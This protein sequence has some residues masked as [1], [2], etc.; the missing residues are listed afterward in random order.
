M[1]RGRC[2]LFVSAL[3]GCLSP[4]AAEP[5]RKGE[6]PRPRTALVLAGGGAL[7]FAHVGV[8][9]VLEE[10]RVPVD[11]VTG[12][13]M[14]AIVG[15]AYASGRS[16]K[17][18]EKV[19]SETDWDKLFDEQPQ[20]RTLPYRFK[21]GRKREIYGDTK[22]GFKDGAL[23]LP[24]GVVSGQNVL[25]VLQSLYGDTPNPVRFDDLPLPFRAVTADIETG[26]AFVPDN[27]DLSTIVRASM[28]VPG[29]F[30][31]VEVDGKMLVDGGITDNLPIDVARSMGAERFIV[32]ELNADLKDRKQL[33]S[34][35]LAIT[36]QIIS[37]LLAQ[38]SAIQKRSLRS[39]DLLIEP[40]LT[41]YASTDFAKA[42]ELMAIGEQAARKILPQLKAF[43]V[44]EDEYVE[45]QQRRAGKPLRRDRIDYI[46]V[47]NDSAMPDAFILS[48]LEVK[49]NEPFDRLKL[50]HGIENVYNL[51]QFSSVTYHTEDTPEGTGVIV[52]A[53]KKTWY[54]QYLR[55]GAAVEDDFKTDT[56]YRL[57]GI[58]RATGL[59]RYGAFADIEAEIGSMPRISTEFYQPLA[60]DSPWFVAPSAG[61]G[62]SLMFPS[63]DG[64]VVARY[65]RTE[66]GAGIKVGRQLG[67]LGE[68]AAGYTRGFGSLK[69]D[70]GDPSL[71]E[72]NYQ[73]GEVLAGVT[74]DATDTPDFPT[75]GF[76]VETAYTA[77]AEGLGSSDTFDQI[78]GSFGVPISYGVNTL[79]LRGSYGVPFD[80]LPP[81]RV[82]S[83]GGFMDLPGYSQ[84]SVLGSSYVTGHA[85]FYRRFRH[86]KMPLF[87]F[88]MF[89]GGS[90]DVASVRSDF[91]NIPD[92]VGF[93][94]GSAFIGMDTPLVP[95]YFAYGYNNFH[96]S[97]IYLVLGRL[98]G[99]R[100]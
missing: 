62:R 91:E 80:T 45:Y 36:G 30:S 57:G 16:V 49:E 4:A 59:N 2:L 94:G 50:Q 85:L 9:R 47:H 79:L 34:S 37:L 92:K 96:E 11:L 41:G 93:V 33:E 68:V 42:L 10:N 13:S 1:G 53:K 60:E 74:L 22:F 99:G 7:G 3:F 72:F 55:I 28:S 97:A 86:M 18:L 82:Y 12:T 35:P 73:I 66:G 39:G 98:S 43:A 23:V 20:R 38:N 83:L 77:A 81:E 88:S 24:S 19:L 46:K 8:I 65:H 78:T 64:D 61:I 44:S 63:M 58:Y 100:R 95:I 27:G 71:P 6:S 70:I 14:G 26:E 84:N 52:E 15:A 56:R 89:G 21:P 75:E 40:N 54:D 67:T 5:V 87:G 31:P 32:V 76:R 69:R 25:P 17:Y 29:F 90:V 48:Q 51:G